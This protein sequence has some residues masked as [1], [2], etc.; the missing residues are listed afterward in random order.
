MEVLQY[1]TQAF[2]VDEEEAAHQ[3]A[4]LFDGEPFPSC[5]QHYD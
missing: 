3:A 5:I 1:V 4:L 2:E